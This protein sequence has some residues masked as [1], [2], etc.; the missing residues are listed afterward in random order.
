MEEYLMWEAYVAKRGSL[1]VGMRVENAVALLAMLIQHARG[2]KADMADFMPHLHREEKEI[3][4]AEA[5]K[6]WK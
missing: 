3:S 6:N 1:N 4:I 2:I 5:M